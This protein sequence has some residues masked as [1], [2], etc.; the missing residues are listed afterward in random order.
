MLKI[1]ND[2]GVM[3]RLDHMRSAVVVAPAYLIDPHEG[4]VR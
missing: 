3:A 4:F 1:G 2:A